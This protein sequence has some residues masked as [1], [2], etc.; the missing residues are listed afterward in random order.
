[1]PLYCHC[2]GVVSHTAAPACTQQRCCRPQGAC[3]QYMQ[4]PHSAP[5]LAAAANSSQHYC[6]GCSSSSLPAGRQGCQHCQCQHCQL[7]LLQ[8]GTSTA[9]TANAAKLPSCCWQLLAAYA[10]RLMSCPEGCQLA[11][12]QGVRPAPAPTTTAGC[13]RC[14]GS[15]PTPAE[16][17]VIGM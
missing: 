13:L 5:L 10:A 9:N 12:P 15:C 7:P 6:S 11:M 17:T 1:M 16:G 2:R 3:I 8:V 14:K 4:P